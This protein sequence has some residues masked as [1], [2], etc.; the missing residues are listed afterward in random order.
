[1]TTIYSYILSMA[2]LESVKASVTRYL[3]HFLL[4]KRARLAQGAL[5]EAK[6]AI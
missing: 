2:H 1:M 6:I 3:E 5:L 4:L